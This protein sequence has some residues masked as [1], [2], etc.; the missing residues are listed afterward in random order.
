MPGKNSG[1]S[2][3]F[4]ADLNAPNRT[5]FRMRSGSTRSFGTTIRSIHSGEDYLRGALQT[6]ASVTAPSAT[7]WNQRAAQKLTLAASP[8]SPTTVVRG[9]VTQSCSD[10]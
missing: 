9:A 1:A 2:V 10:N 4:L 3:L 6:Q 7:D 5:M 8:L